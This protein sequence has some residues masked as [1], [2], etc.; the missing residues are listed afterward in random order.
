MFNVVLCCDENYAKY[1]A[2]LMT[3]IIHNIDKSK[4]LKDFY[5]L[6][7][8]FKQLPLDALSHDKECFS[9][10]IFSDY[11]SSVAREKFARLQFE[12]NKI[13]PTQILFHILNDDE[14][15][16]CPKQGSEEQNYITYYRLK[17]DKVLNSGVCLYL[18]ID[19][20]ALSDIR[21]L[22][23]L[24]LDSKVAAVVVDS[25]FRP[26]RFLTSKDNANENYALNV[27]KYFNAGF[28]LINLKEW[29]EFGVW[30]KFLALAKDYTPLFYD[31][32]ILNAILC[33]RVMWLP[34]EY[35]LQRHSLNAHAIFKDATRRDNTLSVTKQENDYALSH[36]QILHYNWGGMGKPWSDYISLFTHETHYL[37]T[38]VKQW[39]EVALRT[40]SFRDEL[41]NIYVQNELRYNMSLLES[42]LATLQSNLTNLESRVK[43]MHALKLKYRLKNLSRKLRGKPPV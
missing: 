32:D 22:F 17:I 41:K 38:H 28:M 9:F 36:P 21:Y 10:H 19:M 2:V 30:E 3:S 26:T 4:S 23:T 35:N 8:N 13:F 40:A 12:L 7:S 15:Q 31:Q 39:W 16:G 1:A 20:L 6:D 33:E 43:K 11:L 5:N 14:F 24:D 18:D 34:L 37:H 29:R 42:N 25:D 27:D